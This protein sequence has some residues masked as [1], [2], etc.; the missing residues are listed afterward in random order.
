MLKILNHLPVGIG[1]IAKQKTW[2]V[3][4]KSIVKQF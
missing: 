1:A 2:S 4:E 3:Q